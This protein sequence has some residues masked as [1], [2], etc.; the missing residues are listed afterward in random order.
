MY[1]NAVFLHWVRAET[2]NRV[3][4]GLSWPGI[5]GYLLTSLFDAF[6][7]R[8]ETTEQKKKQRGSYTHEFKTD[9]VRLV[10]DEELPVARIA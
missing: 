6:T 5:F 2:N 1:P 10:I 9:A 7:R 4:G 3:Y 8:S